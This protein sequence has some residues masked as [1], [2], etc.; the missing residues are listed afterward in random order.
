MALKTPPLSCHFQS[1]S[2]GSTDADGASERE[3]K[4]VVF[5]VVV[6]VVVVVAWFPGEHGDTV[7]CMGRLFSF[8]WPRKGRRRPHREGRL[9]R[10]RRRH[11]GEGGSSGGSSSSSSAVLGRQVRR[12]RPRFDAAAAAAAIDDPAT[13]QNGARRGDDDDDDD[14]DDQRRRSKNRGTKVSDRRRRR[15]HSVK[16]GVTS[17]AAKKEAETNDKRVQHLVH[18][19][20]AGSLCCRRVRKMQPSK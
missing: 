18:D 5:V 20:A 9:G 19:G 8:G 12:P 17:R 13:F 14:D 11:Q 2:R 15:R 16:A 1:V 4:D 10:R 7:I 6:V 3:G